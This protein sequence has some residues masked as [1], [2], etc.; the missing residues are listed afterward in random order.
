MIEACN[1]PLS[2]ILSNAGQNFEVIKNELE[3]S[4][5]PKYG[6]DARNNKYCDMIELGIIDPVKVT[7]SA[8][9]NAV[10]IAGMMITT[11]C[12]LME[13]AGDDSIKVDA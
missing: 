1:A 2:A 5:N 3:K 7:R 6:Y 4:D 9:E 10:S 11:E 8:L 13:E 12:T